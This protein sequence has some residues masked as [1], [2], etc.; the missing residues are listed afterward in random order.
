MTHNNNH[1]SQ[2]DF[3]EQV[4]SF[5][6]GENNE[7]EKKSFEAHLLNCTSCT[8]ELTGFTTVR[9]SIQEW[10]SEE[11][12]NLLAPSFEIPSAKK[13]QVVSSSWLQSIRAFLSLPLAWGAVAVPS[14]LVLAGL[15]WLAVSPSK[16][17]DVAENKTETINK[18]VPSPKTQNVVSD[19]V[20]SVNN[21]KAET[22][23]KSVKPLITVKN[24][25]EKFVAK[26]S[27][28]TNISRNTNLPAV[29]IKNPAPVN[30]DK[31]VAKTSVKKSK[32]NSVPRLA[33]EDEEEDAL[34][35]S[36]ILDEVSLK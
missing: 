6:Y 17:L 26:S 32:T 20:E 28:E 23:E 24:N 7:A 18:T 4:V 33:G 15:F 3:A 19:N 13:E 14:I 16:K 10:R 35:L 36:D 12:A 34:R 5:L 22:V 2:C 9:S 21:E 29:K 25:T 11:F 8:D 30:S 1:H 27:V 31:N